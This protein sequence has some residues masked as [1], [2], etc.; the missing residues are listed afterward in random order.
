V[1]KAPLQASLFPGKKT[2]G[3]KT[4]SLIKPS[5]DLKTRIAINIHK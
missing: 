2:F 5:V 4:M 1:E 3:S